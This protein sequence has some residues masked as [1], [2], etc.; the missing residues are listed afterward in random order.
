MM[1]HAH[2]RPVSKGME[3]RLGRRTQRLMSRDA[4]AVRYYATDQRST[5]ANV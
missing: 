2:T 5:G 4:I 3:G 1:C